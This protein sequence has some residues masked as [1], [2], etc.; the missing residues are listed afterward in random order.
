MASLILVL[1]GVMVATAIAENTLNVHL[2]TGEGLS[3]GVSYGTVLVEGEQDGT[4]F[5]GMVC[6]DYV[7]QYT[8]N[9][10]CRQAGFLRALSFG[11][12]AYT[13]DAY[14]LT[15]DYA[16]NVL[17]IKANAIDDLTCPPGADSLSDCSYKLRGCGEAYHWWRALT[18]ECTNTAADR[19]ADSLVVDIQQGEGEGGRKEGTIVVK[20]TYAGYPFSGLLYN[21][22]PEMNQ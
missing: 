18:L 19:S 4:A 14:K 8:A 11:K 16:L 6:K 7:D 9:F 15:E 2:E 22:G 3:E 5:S 13:D 20:G 12:H 1:C 21:L 17:G 10:L